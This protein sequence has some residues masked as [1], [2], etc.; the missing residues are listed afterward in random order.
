MRHVFYIDCS[1][2]ASP[3]PNSKGGI[4]CISP[5]AIIG[6]LKASCG[7]SPEIT[8]TAAQT[9]RFRSAGAAASVDNMS[10]RVILSFS[11]VLSARP[12]DDAIHLSIALIQK[13][14]SRGIIKKTQQIRRNVNMYIAKERRVGASLL[15][16]TLA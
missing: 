12:S 4:R 9:A 10:L 7:T 15:P 3:N 8:T 5:M 2:T 6:P 1:P 16:C 11:T 14:L 13:R